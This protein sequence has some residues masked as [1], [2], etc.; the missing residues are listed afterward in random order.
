MINQLTGEVPEYPQ[1]PDMDEELSYKERNEAH[2][3]N[4]SWPE[5]KV[6]CLDDLTSWYEQ[7]AKHDERIKNFVEKI[8]EGIKT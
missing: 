1:D 2:E 4:K 3:R 5:N 7:Y 6:F 8:A